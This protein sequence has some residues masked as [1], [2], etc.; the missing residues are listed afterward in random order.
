[1]GAGRR[2]SEDTRSEAAF[3]REIDCRFPYDDEARAS[4]LIEEAGGISANAA[5]MV[6]A[7]VVTPGRSAK[8]SVDRRLALLDE[9]ERAFDHPLR[10]MVLDVARRVVRGEGFGQAE[11]VGFLRRVEGHPGQYDALRVVSSC[12]VDDFDEIDRIHEEIRARWRT[13]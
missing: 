6:V 7:E 10:E 9:I 5:F 2:R 4:R 11:V 8:V 12:P 13:A 3:I 1:V